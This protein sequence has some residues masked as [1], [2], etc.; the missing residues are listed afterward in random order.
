M[1]DLEQATEA[2]PLA[3]IEDDGRNI[4]SAVALG[5]IAASAMLLSSA[6]A[7]A[8]AQPAMTDID[9][10]NFFLNLEYLQ[11]Q[12]YGYATTGASI[13]SADIAG[14]GAAGPVIGARAIAFADPV[15]AHFAREVAAADLAHVRYMR[16]QLLIAG[17]LAVAQPAI[18]FT[19]AFDA[20]MRAAGVSN[21]FN[22]FASDDNFLL[23]AFFLQDFAV[24]AYKGMAA[25]IS[26]RTFLE[27]LMGIMATKAYHA[28]F[29]R[30][31]LLQKGASNPA[32]INA[33][34]AISNARDALDG[35]MDLDQGI[36]PRGSASNIA[37][38]DANGVAYG[39]T[40]AQSLN[41]AYLQSSAVSAG[42]FFPN[43]LNGNLRVSNAN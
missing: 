31:S 36:S 2:L 1:T 43:G 20:A 14:V 35:P 24:S 10:L 12:Y 33:A 28:A 4:G 19:A 9:I 34:D 30:Q 11:A 38:A 41:I 37:P 40:P 18:D 29:V 8:Q 7:S 27:G 26:N 21:S 16:E 3:E 13:P 5:T 6:P 15:L 22:A 32:L 25:L 17:G 39:R 42:G 23:G